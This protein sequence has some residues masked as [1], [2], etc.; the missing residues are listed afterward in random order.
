MVRRAGRTKVRGCPGSGEEV[1]WLRFSRLRVMCRAVPHKVDQ[2]QH[3]VMG[4]GGERLVKR[5]VG[6]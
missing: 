2:S 6:N 1:Q 4:K 3:G 5:R